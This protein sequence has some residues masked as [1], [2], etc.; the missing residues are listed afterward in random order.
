VAHS[1]PGWRRKLAHP[2]GAG[3][4]P[5]GHLRGKTQGLTTKAHGV[6]NPARGKSFD[7]TGA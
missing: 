1:R 2:I 7:A 5:G 3:A 6:N 4:E